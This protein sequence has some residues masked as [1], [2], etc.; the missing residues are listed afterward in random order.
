M[1]L[2]VFDD[3][4]EVVYHRLHNNTKRKLEDR[5][6]EVIEGLP[7]VKDLVDRLERGR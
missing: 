2:P 5:A 6:F 7:A 4:A 1:A 3:S